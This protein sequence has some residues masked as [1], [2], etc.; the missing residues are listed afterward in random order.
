MRAKIQFLLLGLHI[1]CEYLDRLCSGRCSV[2]ISG[3]EEMR[4][5]FQLRSEVFISHRNI[6]ARGQQHE[7]QEYRLILHVWGGTDVLIF[8]KERL[9]FSK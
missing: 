8:A 3:Q 4:A 1:H 2:T 6:C 5:A 9:N 7:Y